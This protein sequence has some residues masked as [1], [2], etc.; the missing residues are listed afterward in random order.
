MPVD[1]PLKVKDVTGVDGLPAVE[2]SLAARQAQRAL[3]KPASAA[4]KVG[5]YTGWLLKRPVDG[6][7]WR[8][9]IQVHRALEEPLHGVQ[10]GQTVASRPFPVPDGETAV[11]A[12]GHIPGH[13]IAVDPTELAGYPSQPIDKLRDRPQRGSRPARR[14]VLLRS[15]VTAL[16]QLDAL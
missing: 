2:R 9:V 14:A 4:A 3:R 15:P 6:G 16:A 12:S 8:E 7:R 5:E 11:L 13:P 1:A 10:A